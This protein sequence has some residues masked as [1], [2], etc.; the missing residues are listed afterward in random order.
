[1]GAEPL[2]CFQQVPI[3]HS[4]CMLR[5]GGFQLTV[6]SLACRPWR[7]PGPVGCLV[8]CPATSANLG[9]QALPLGGQQ[10]F[11]LVQML[12]HLCHRH[13]VKNADSEPS[14]VTVTFLRILS[15]AVM[16][17]WWHLCHRYLV[18]ARLFE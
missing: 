5:G 7:S 11:H 4:Q 2:P 8:P 17:G 3:Q 1:M 6:L 12:A 10:N 16:W 9:L 15:S 13:V 18:N 14:P